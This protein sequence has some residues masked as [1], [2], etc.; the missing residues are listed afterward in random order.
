MTVDGVGQ[1]NK[2]E[3]T[4]VAAKSGKVMEL[5][6]NSKMRMKK[7]TLNMNEQQMTSTS[8]II[9]SLFILRSSCLVDIYL[10]LFFSLIIRIWNYLIIKS[11]W[12][13]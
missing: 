3:K 8:E 5:E 6:K 12:S 4:N 2:M 7:S 13:E 10:F 11:T 9:G 1:R